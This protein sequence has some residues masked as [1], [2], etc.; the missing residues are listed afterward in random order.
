M[1]LWELKLLCD[2]DLDFSSLGLCGYS[3]PYSYSAVFVLCVFSEYAEA[4][5]NPIKHV[6][7]LH[8]RE[9]QLAVLIEDNNEV[10]LSEICSLCSRQSVSVWC[11][12]TLRH[13]S[14]LFSSMSPANP[15]RESPG[16]RVMSFQEVN[17]LPPSTPSTPSP[18]RNP[19]LTSSEYLHKVIS[20]LSDTFR[21]EFQ[22]FCCFALEWV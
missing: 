9:T 15:K 11:L 7:E 6:S 5:T 12:Q 13:S 17:P 16:E 14:I 22:T 1:K 4:L 3:W 21:V 18:H 8:K 20:P 2:T 10:R 19:H